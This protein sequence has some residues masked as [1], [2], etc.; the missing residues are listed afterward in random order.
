VLSVDFGGTQGAGDLIE[1]DGGWGA[2]GRAG[3]ET[4][5]SGRDGDT[6]LRR[7]G[8]GAVLGILSPGEDRCGVEGFPMWERVRDREGDR[9]ETARRAT[10]A[11]GIVVPGADGAKPSVACERCLPG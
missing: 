10:G 9:S 11:R 7:P 6:A 8:Y 2:G 3:H 1:S 5:S 4:S